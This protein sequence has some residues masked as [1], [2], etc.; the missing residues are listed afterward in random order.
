LLSWAFIFSLAEIL[1]FFAAI[2]SIITCV[3]ADGSDCAALPSFAQQCTGRPYSLTML[4]NGG[5]CSQS[6]T[7]QL[8]QTDKYSCLDS[9]SGGVPT[10]PGSQVYVVVSALNDTSIIYTS[11]YVGVGSTFQVT[12]GVQKIQAALNVTFYSSN[13]LSAATQIQSLKFETTCSQN[14]FLKDRFGAVELVGLVNQEQGVLSTTASVSFDVSATVPSNLTESGITVTSFIAE[15]SF[16]TFNFTDQFSGQSVAPGASIHASFNITLDLSISRRYAV[17]SSIS[18][19][20]PTGQIYQGA[21]SYEFAAGNALP[22]AVTPTASVPSIP[23]ATASISAAIE[24]SL[25]SDPSISCDGLKLPSISKCTG[26]KAQELRFIYNAKSCDAS[27][28]TS[29]LFQC[30][31]SNGGPVSSP[32]SITVS[33]GMET[34]DFFSGTV[35]PGV[36]FSTLTGG[37]YAGSLSIKV[38]SLVNN[39]PGLLLQTLTVSPSCGGSSDVSLLTQYGSLQLTAFK[40]TENGLQSAVDVISQS[41]VVSNDGVGDVTVSWANITSA[42][43]GTTSVVSPPGLQ[44]GSGQSK[45][46]PFATTPIN[47]YASQGQSFSSTFN[48]SGVGSGA[49]QQPCSNST[50]LSFVVGN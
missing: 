38:S 30:T 45:S 33:N 4:L 43:Y 9:V 42:L 17:T 8:G 41:F 23:S 1:L 7:P 24:C 5:D 25:A 27:N 35:E 19:L 46:F 16:G 37:A 39:A 31:D 12:D 40:N 20:T 6:F 11:E 15:T 28:S 48:V 49:S 22:P 14:L 26:S 21:G 10:S 13:L 32:V 34:V 36:I 44:L 47:L 29:G 18:G 3:S 2:A 50:Q